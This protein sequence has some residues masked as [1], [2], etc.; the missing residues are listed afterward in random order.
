VEERHEILPALEFPVREGSHLRGDLRPAL[1]RAKVERLGSDTR[2][3]GLSMTRPTRYGAL[4]ASD[5]F[6]P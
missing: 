1:H 5:L 2:R 3:P 4:S 6:C